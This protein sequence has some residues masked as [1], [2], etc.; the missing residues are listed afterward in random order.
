MAGRWLLGGAVGVLV[1]AQLVKVGIAL[2]A[3]PSL[4]YRRP[5]VFWMALDTPVMPLLLARSN[6]YRVQVITTI[7]QRPRAIHRWVVVHA[8]ITQWPLLALQT[9]VMVLAS[10]TASS[11]NATAAS[12]LL[13]DSV[14]WAVSFLTV[15]LHLLLFLVLLVVVVEPP[16]PKISLASTGSIQSTSV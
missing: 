12:V 4:P 3:H 7:R 11:G 5:H 9:I 10:S 2:L 13:L 6:F 1:V 8:V 14:A 16:P 15:L